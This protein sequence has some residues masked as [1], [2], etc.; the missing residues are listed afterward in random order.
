VFECSVV[1]GELA[2][3]NETTDFRWVTEDQAKELTLFRTHVRKVPEAFRLHRQPGA[4]PAF[5]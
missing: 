2:A 3:S 4:A 5:H 1:S